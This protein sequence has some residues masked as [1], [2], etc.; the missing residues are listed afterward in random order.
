MFQKEIIYIEFIA[1][2]INKLSDVFCERISKEILF[3]MNFGKTR[4]FFVTQKCPDL[5]QILESFDT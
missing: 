2:L 4:L 5:K 3:S 1:K